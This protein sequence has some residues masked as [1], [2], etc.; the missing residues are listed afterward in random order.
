[1]RAREIEHHIDDALARA[2]IGPL[3][4][5]AGTKSWEAVGIG[6]FVGLGRGASRVEWRVFDQPHQLRC[7]TGPNCRNARRHLGK[8]VRVGSEARCRLPFR[9][10]RIAGL[11]RSRAC[12][13]CLG[14][15]RS[16]SRRCSERHTPLTRCAA[17]ARPCP[18]RVARQ[19]RSRAHATGRCGSL[20]GYHSSAIPRRRLGRKAPVPKDCGRG[21]MVDAQA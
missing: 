10:T 12:G 13:G 5:A 9:R 4:A 17:R 16:A 8:R 7:R 15:T 18:V 6:E 21:G 20:K 11:R 19:V 14:S 3:P 1:V 2:V